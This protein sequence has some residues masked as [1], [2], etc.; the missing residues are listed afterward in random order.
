MAIKCYRTGGCGPYE[1]YSCHECPANNPVYHC[2]KECGHIEI[3][4]SHIL[5]GHILS[6]PNYS[7]LSKHVMNKKTS[8]PTL[9][10]FPK[11]KENEEKENEQKKKVKIIKMKKKDIPDIPSIE[12]DN[13]C[14]ACTL[15]KYKSKTKFAYSFAEYFHESIQEE[16]NILFYIGKNNSTNEWLLYINYSD[17]DYDLREIHREF[18]IPIKYCPVCGRE[19]K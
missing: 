19:L 2:L 12:E 16:E 10:L 4:K 5:T 3:C 13:S 9:L 14:P 7:D 11:E 18:S 15:K 17:E 8:V 6:C 1:M